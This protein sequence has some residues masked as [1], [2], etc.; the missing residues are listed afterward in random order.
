MKVPQKVSREITFFF[1]FGMGKSYAVKSSKPHL[2]SSFS[3]PNQRKTSS[4][5]S[6]LFSENYC[7]E[8]ALIMFVYSNNLLL[9][10]G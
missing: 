3:L 9:N 2:L 1:F 8:Y 7:N 4:S 6:K 5:V 10:L